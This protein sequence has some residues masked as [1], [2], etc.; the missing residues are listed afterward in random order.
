MER[1]N[2]RHI[3]NV[4]ERID[5]YLVSVGLPVYGLINDKFMLSLSPRGP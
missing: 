5:R 1:L 3:C 2:T 4:F